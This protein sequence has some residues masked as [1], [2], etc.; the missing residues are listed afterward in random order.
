MG[1]V[2]TRGFNDLWGFRPEYDE[3]LMVPTQVSWISVFLF[4]RGGG[5]PPNGGFDES[6]I[7]FIDFVGVSNPALWGFSIE[8]FGRSFMDFT[9]S[10]LWGLP[11]EEDSMKA[12]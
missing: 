5:F 6:F 11:E 3:N 9:C 7:D 2:L 12:S 1:M 10:A 8:G 4:L